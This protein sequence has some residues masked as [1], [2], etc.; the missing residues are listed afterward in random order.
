MS[1]PIVVVA[2]GG[3]PDGAPSSDFAAGAATVAAAV[4]NEKANLALEASEGAAAGAE[5]A[6][7]EAAAAADT[8]LSAEIG[9]EDLADRV[10]QLEDRMMEGFGHISDALADDGTE[11]GSGSPED[12]GAPGPKETHVETHHEVTTTTTRPHPSR[13]RRSSGG[14]FEKSPWFRGR[15]G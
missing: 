10:D 11:T 3:E 5:Y 12:D 6:A 13:L 7:S 14:A 1:E 9:V 15:K 8:A 4:A 2:Q